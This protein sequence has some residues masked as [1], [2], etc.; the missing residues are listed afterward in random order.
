[1]NE[2]SGAPGI[3]RRQL[4]RMGMLG[5]AGAVAGGVVA[6]AR[7]TASG[8]LLPSPNPSVTKRLV[9]TDGWMDLPG[10]E[11]L[12][13]FGFVEAD[14]DE[15]I[16]RVIRRHKGKVQVPAP[17]LWVD[18]ET[19][20]YLTLTN[21]GLIQRPDLDDSHTVHWHGFRNP[22][23]VFDG[24]PEVS[25]AVPVGRDFPYFYRPHDP[26]TYMYH[27]HFEDVEH[28][29]MGMNG[30]VFVRP[31]MGPKFA[32]DLSSTRF[33]RQYALLLNEIDTRPHDNLAAVQEFQWTDYHPN[34]FIINGR[35]YPDTLKPN[36]DP[37]L[38]SQPSSSLVQC[39]PGDRILL[40]LV[41]L[42][43]ESQ[44]MELAGLPMRVI[45]EDAVVLRGRDGTNLSYSAN[46]V[47]IGPGES[48]DVLIEAP[49]FGKVGSQVDAI[50]RH[51]VYPFRSRNAY[52]L[53]NDGA[54][55]LGGMATQIRVYKG[56]PLLPQVNANET[57]QVAS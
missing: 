13:I 12:Y 23:A 5:A 22:V 33:D 9:A 39:N 36:N 30:V 54:S 1:V 42:G 16:N 18:D 6:A 25:I 32:Y 50:G 27:C 29:Q 47:S 14:P 41:N 7:G 37:D 4:L 34:Y 11:P 10:R 45:G 40:R 46:I 8:G 57:P 20:L 56:S 49:P 24:V 48:R 26:G 38:P 43:Y 55:G 52:A 3:S 31:L 2:S 44:A 53:Q 28:V 19:D 15:E 51:N 21:V 35:A 17:L